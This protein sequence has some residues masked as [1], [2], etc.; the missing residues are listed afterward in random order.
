M[1][2]RVRNR[3]LIVDDSPIVRERLL[4]LLSDLPNVEVV[5]EADMAFDAIQAVRKLKPAAVILD[6][7]MPGGSGMQV[8]EAAKREPV[9]P[10]VIMFSNFSDE[11]YRTKCLA[12]GADHFLDKSDDVDELLQLLRNLPRPKA[13]R[14]RRFQLGGGR[15]SRNSRAD[16]SPPA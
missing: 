16:V 10:L 2:P 8:L 15:N 5:G 14:R 6:I 7:S 12:L 13:G 11:P 3:V 1:K 9:P 4:A